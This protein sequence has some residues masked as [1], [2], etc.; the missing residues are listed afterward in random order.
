ME[1]KRRLTIVPPGT[2]L[3]D[4]EEGEVDEENFDIAYEDEL[5]YDEGEQDDYYERY[6]DDEDLEENNDQ[7][8]EDRHNLDVDNYREEDDDNIPSTPQ[9]FEELNALY[10]PKFEEKLTKIQPQIQSK[11]AIPVMNE[12]Q[13]NAVE[14]KINQEMLSPRNSYPEP[15]PQRLSPQPQYVAEVTKV[16]PEAS[17]VKQQQPLEQKSLLSTNPPINDPAEYDDEEYSDEIYEG[18]EEDESIG[19]DVDD[20]ELMKRLE[21]K[22]GKLPEHLT[23]GE[24]EDVEQEE[25]LGESDLDDEESWTSKVHY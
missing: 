12:L 24:D 20:D 25:Y 16:T 15:T 8:L 11:N 18:E 7:D 1:I 3:G 19:S 17:S 21:A 23:V 10:K 22:Y 14:M 4:Q 2:Y 6:S 13:T 9:T 5:I